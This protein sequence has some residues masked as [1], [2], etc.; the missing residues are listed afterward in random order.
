MVRF[1][2]SSP[3]WK[4]APSKVMSQPE[5]DA[6]LTDLGGKAT[7]SPQA[8]VK[9]IIFRLAVYCGL[10]V[11]EICGL[12]LADVLIDGGLAVIKVRAEI[13]KGKK[14]REVPI[15]SEATVSDLRRWKALRSS[16][17]ATKADAFLVSVSAD[18][19]GNRFS[20]Q[21]ARH[22]FQAACKV[23]GEERAQ[24]L[25]IHDGRHTA[26]SQALHKGVPLALVRDMLG[27]SSI[28]ITNT[29]VGLFRDGNGMGYNLD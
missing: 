4:I 27:H 15:L 19:M 14:A 21:G 6:V 18:S 20:R 17:G 22:R 25:T 8:L 24:G 2:A 23:L 1:A 5:I 9:V 13:A 16:Q 10:R 11:S 29:Y 3:S 26:A 28:A 7:T 12:N